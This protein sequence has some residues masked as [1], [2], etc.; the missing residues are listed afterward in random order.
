MLALSRG[1]GLPG[2]AAMPSRWQRH[3]LH[4]CRPLLQPSAQEVRQWLAQRG[5]RSG[6]DWV[7]DPSNASLQFTRNRIRA[8]LLPVL[9]EVFPH[10]RT[11]FARSAAHAAQA[12]LLLHELALQDLQH[13]GQPPRIAALQQLGPAR[14]ANALREWFKA[15]CG[16]APS[17]AQLHELQ[18]QIAAC[19][20]RGHRIELK[21]AHGV[22]RRTGAHLVYQAA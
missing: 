6:V 4:Y 8:R 21:A 2:L 15:E 7:E 12:Q 13:T 20:T 17:A 14:Q 10:F 1:A 11:S 18:S 16:A 22:V 19:T 3:G 9:D 5:L